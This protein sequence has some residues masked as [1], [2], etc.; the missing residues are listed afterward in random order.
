MVAGVGLA[1]DN[2]VVGDVVDDGFGVGGD[3]W[4]VHEHGAF[5]VRPRIDT[6]HREHGDPGI[7]SVSIPLPG[8]LNVGSEEAGQRFGQLGV[9]GGWQVDLQPSI[10]D[11]PS[12][13]QHSQAV[14]NQRRLS[15]LVLCSKDSS[16]VP[17]DGDG[18][19]GSPRLWLIR[20]DTLV[21]G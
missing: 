12:T 17:H 11:V 18:A 9:D 5:T 7:S 15:P 21:G 4:D 19:V 8:G 1:E 10:T 20:V 3:A 13:A 14:V 16:R 6:R 2:Q